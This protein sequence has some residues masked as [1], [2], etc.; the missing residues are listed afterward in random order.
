MMCV[1]ATLLSAC[2]EQVPPS[3]TAEA[4]STPETRTVQQGLI[5]LQDSALWAAPAGTPSNSGGPTFN[6]EVEILR[7]RS[8]TTTPPVVTGTGIT[9][10]P[11]NTALDGKF[12]QSLFVRSGP[13]ENQ[14]PDPDCQGTI[15]IPA[16]ITVVGV[17]GATDA[18]VI[19]A[20]SALGIPG[21]DYTSRSPGMEA[22]EMPVITVNGD[23]T[24]TVTWSANI[25]TTPF[26]DTFRLLLDHGTAFREGT[27]SVRLTRGDSINLGGRRSGMTSLTF[28]LAAAECG[29]GVVSSGESCDD[30]NTAPGDGC[31]ATC[32]VEPGFT[33]PNAGGQCLTVD[34]V[35]PAA[36]A[37]LNASPVS[38]SGTATAGASVL[39]EII[40][41]TMT[42]VGSQTVTATGGTWNASIATSPDGSYLARATV[43]TTGGSIS[44]SNAFILDTTAPAAPVV[45]APANGSRT[46]DST[47]TYTGTAEAGSTVTIFVDGS[48][49]GTTTAS[50]AG[51]WTFTQPTALPDG[52]HTV[53]ATATDAAGNTSPRSNANTFS[54]DTVAPVV[55]IAA[56][57]ANASLNATDVTVTGTV[58]DQTATVTASVNNGAAQPV[59]VGAGGALSLPLMGL[60]EGSYTV[61]F[62]ATDAAGNTSTASRTFTIDR[63]APAVTI[64][65]PAQATQTRDNTPTISGT[66]EAGSSVA[67]E[68]YN[69]QN[70][71]A[72]T[73]TV[74]VDAQGQWTTDT[75]VLAD[76]NYTVLVTA[77]DAAGN[78]AGAGPRQFTV[79][80]TAPTVTITQPANNSATNDTTP[81]IAG[82]S[83]QGASVLV[84]VLNA[85]SQVVYSATVT[86]GA[87]GF[88]TDTTA[89]VSGVYTAR[90]TATDAAGNTS[91]PA[92]VSFTIDTSVP[93]LAITAP[94]NNSATNDTTP[95]LSG[96]ADAGATVTLV[97]RDAQNTSRFNATVTA[98]AGGVWTTTSAA[99][100]EGAY[101][102][103]ATTTNLAGT[104]VSV[105][106]S[107]TVDLSV[108][109]MVATPGPDAQIADSTPTI[110]GSVEQGASVSIRIVDAVT[111]MVAF[112]VTVQPDAFGI[113]TAT[114]T[115][116]P[117]GDYLVQVSAVD[118]LGNMATAT[119][120]PI[121]IDTAAPPVAITQP[122][123]GAIL[124]MSPSIEGTSE[125]GATILVVIEDSAGMLLL[126]TQVTADAAGAWSVATQLADAGAYT[127]TVVAQ[128]LAGNSAEASADFTLDLDMASVAIIQPASGA[129]VTT[130]RPTVSGTASADA[131]VLVELL[132]AQGVVV[133]SATVNPDAQG[134]WTYTAQMMLTDG[135]YTARATATRPN[136]TTATARSG[137]TIDTIAPAQVTITAP[138]ADALLNSQ[139]ITVSGTA[140]PGDM[141]TIALDG[142]DVTTVTADAN[143]AWTA[144]LTNVTEGAHTIEASSPTSSAVVSVTVDTMA[145]MIA[146]SSPATGSTVADGRPTFTGTGEPGAT[147]IIEVDGVEVDRVMVGPDGMWSWM[148]TD[149]LEVGERTITV[150][151]RDA[152]GNTSQ[153]IEIVITV[154]E[155]APALTVAITSPTEGATTDAQPVISGTATPGAAISVSIDGQVVG[156]TVAS[157]EGNWSLALADVDVTLEAGAHTVSVTA[158]AGGASATAGPVNFTV[159]GGELVDPNA[160]VSLNGSGCACATAPASG[161]SPRPVWLALVGLVGLLRRRR[162]A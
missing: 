107:F 7:E 135:T 38:V 19:A 146:V 116:L 75:M 63:T 24:T 154:E 73:A 58:N 27:I 156:T 44:D 126:S 41:D 37:F 52:A 151:G 123:D 28:P 89:L 43:T 13:F 66:G 5:P 42:V 71:L 26:T 86:A 34:L 129:T 49:V 90:A 145:P 142:Q 10:T 125:A 53:R 97:V 130:S 144:T 18:E 159:A 54:V 127:V 104:S 109:L 72:Y 62:T 136:A 158:T 128:D 35:T 98:N 56:P 17:S 31:S 119:E 100:T 55:T 9:L 117:D 64:V 8:F 118:A 141:I 150:T 78:T 20:N 122:T 143:G 6:C 106:V 23:G 140:E 67:V 110:A 124:G 46:N 134:A 83:E 103:D 47:P 50:G 133:E 111:L 79:D 85:Q 60:A 131:S 120:V 14:T 84:E 138:A 57:A 80:V 162:L 161:D 108:A 82:V 155:P 68:V 16:G 51:T 87:Q 101:T 88:T 2:A 102:L 160:D 137:F 36:N 1:F 152:A 139:T 3:Q 153:S 113:W 115:T 61:V 70:Q 147:V 77:T 40:N 132:D 30:S 114:T 4:P 39:V 99:L 93:A 22:G 95:T 148:P 157:A 33:C 81:T 112:T 12:S 91:Q 121:T 11:S 69:A 76:G 105:Q 15:I 96:T 48:S 25:N 149:A 94:A 65:Q 29:D 74:V 32:A 92:T 21:I 59:M 45:T